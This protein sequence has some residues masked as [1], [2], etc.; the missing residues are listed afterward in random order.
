MGAREHSI[1]T[2]CQ[3]LGR[4]P[5]ITVESLRYVSCTATQTPLFRRAMTRIS[6]MRSPLHARL[7]WRKLSRAVHSCWALGRDLSLWDQG[8]DS[9][10]AITE[11]APWQL[12]SPSHAVARL[13]TLSEHREG[14]LESLHCLA[15]LAGLTERPGTASSPDPHG[16]QV[17][18]WSGE[19]LQSARIAFTP[20]RQTF[21]DTQAGQME[22]LRQD[23]SER[24]TSRAGVGGQAKR[25]AGSRA[26]GNVAPS[27]RPVEGT[28]SQENSDNERG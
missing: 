7:G 12:A 17:F 15:P 18:A 5:Q 6:H 25:S 11:Q 14:G 10:S 19:G 2:V 4:S 21:L 22:G 16:G 24:V 26:G 20:L 13:A 28:G 9:S 3:A 1:P 27:R 8:L 23:S